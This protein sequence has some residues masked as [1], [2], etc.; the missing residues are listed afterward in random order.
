MSPV[1]TCP[2]CEATC[3]LEVTFGDGDRVVAGHAG[4]PM[5][6]SRKGSSAPRAGRWARC[7]TTPTACARR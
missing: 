6:S 5:T 4:T 3:G 7:T 2:L 1:T